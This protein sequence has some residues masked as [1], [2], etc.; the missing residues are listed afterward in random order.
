[1]YMLHYTMYTIILCISYTMYKLC[2][3][4]SI[5]SSVSGQSGCFYVS[6]IVN[7]AAVNIGM[8]VSF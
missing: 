3:N 8:H 4:L 5:H 7:T 6:A 2:I 1:M